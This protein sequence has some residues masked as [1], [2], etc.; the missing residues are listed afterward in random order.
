MG[1]ARVG[2]NAWLCVSF[3]P[4]LAQTLIRTL[5]DIWEKL[6]V[7]M[8]PLITSFLYLRAEFLD[9]EGGWTRSPLAA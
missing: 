3:G 2:E 8:E 9:L 1:K 6:F 7:P 4:M 5:S